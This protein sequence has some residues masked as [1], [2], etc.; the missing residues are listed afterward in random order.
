MIECFL[1]RIEQESRAI[2]VDLGD[3]WVYEKP[4]LRLCPFW[5]QVARLPNYFA[6]GLGETPKTGFSW[7]R[8]STNWEFGSDKIDL[9]RVNSA[10]L[11]RLKYS[12]APTPLSTPLVATNSQPCAP[13][14][15]SVTSPL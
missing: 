1:A 11:R 5:A 2:S 4:S 7:S 6:S 3:Q 14:W 8:E 10:Y 9:A 12:F 13:S 15:L